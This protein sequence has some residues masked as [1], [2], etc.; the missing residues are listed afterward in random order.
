VTH[1]HHR[2][3][4]DESARS[5]QR[6]ERRGLSERFAVCPMPD[7]SRSAGRA[8]AQPETSCHVS[9]T[10]PLKILNTN[11]MSSAAT[12][13]ENMASDRLWRFECVALILQFSGWNLLCRAASQKGL[14]SSAA[15]GIGF[16]EFT[17]DP[18]SRGAEVVGRPSLTPQRYHR[19]NSAR[20]LR[21]YPH[22]EQ[23]DPG[24]QHRDAGEHERIQRVDPEQKAREEARQAVRR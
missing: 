10:S 20:A 2:P 6:L 21:G 12:H 11:T 17:A 19:I 15:F 24:Q 3:N 14:F 7:R 16:A 1:D 13:D 4:A 5:G 8:F 23:C 18:R 22:R 9:L